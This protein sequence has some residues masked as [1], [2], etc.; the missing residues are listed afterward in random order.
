MP[1]GPRPDRR[2]RRRDRRGH[3]VKASLAIAVAVAMFGSWPAHAQNAGAISAMSTAQRQ[4]CG[5][6]A[7]A[8]YYYLQ[9]DCTPIAL[10][11]PCATPGA[12]DEFADILNQE[13]V[14]PR[15]IVRIDQ[16]HL[17][18]H[19]ANNPLYSIGLVC[20][21]I[22]VF[23]TGQYISGTMVINETNT[24]SSN[25]ISWQPDCWGRPYGYFGP[26]CPANNP[27]SF[28]WKLLG[29][30]PLGTFYLDEE[31]VGHGKITADHPVTIAADML[32]DFNKVQLNSTLPYIS[33]ILHIEMDCNAGQVHGT[34]DISFDGRMGG[35]FATSEESTPDD[36]WRASENIWSEVSRELCKSQPEPLPPG[37][38]AAFRRGQADRQQWDSWLAGQSGDS[39]AGATYWFSHR[40]DPHAPNC[41]V[42]QVNLHTSY[43]WMFG[44]DAA[45]KQLAVPDTMR[46]MSTDYRLGWDSRRSPLSP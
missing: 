25:Q 45:M 31:H 14:F 28:T 30:Y 4:S 24:S 3:P 29:H 12:S 10:D 6:P 43:E 32:V 33:S 40:N 21:G 19:L 35:G 8:G 36:P 9:G 41:P 44:C 16:S 13:H 17:R 20:H 22:L 23:D 42:A 26:T 27:R 34:G 2:P 1:K 15:R 7:P 39:L 37:P 38:S 18:L 46:R 5:A 11:A